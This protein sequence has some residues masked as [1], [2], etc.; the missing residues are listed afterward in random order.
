VVL[1]RIAQNFCC[2]SAGE[3]GERRAMEANAPAKSLREQAAHANDINM[4]AA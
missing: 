1:L 4:Q 3:D 2:A